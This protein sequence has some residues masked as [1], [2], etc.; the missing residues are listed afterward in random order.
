MTT[1]AWVVNASPLILYAR[2]DQLVLF[3]LL[4]PRLIIP[5]AVIAEVRSGQH[6]D[7][8]ASRAVAWATQYRYPDIAIPATV[9]RW[10][11]G[12]GESQVISYCLKESR[13]AVLDDQMAR[14]CV[15][16]H[17]LRMIGSLGVI[18]RAKE[19]GFLNKARPWVYKLKSEGMYVA[20]GL[21]ERSLSAIGESQ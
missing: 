13:C 18:L 3:E 9:D 1:E 4:A 14:R 2:I 21:I 20:D 8:T 12:L 6:K 5:E 11:L 10:N 17:A 15:S 19:R 7:H 16:A